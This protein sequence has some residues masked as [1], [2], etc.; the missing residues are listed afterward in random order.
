MKSSIK[1]HNTDIYYKDLA[2]GI[3]F[4]TKNIIMCKV[5][6]ENAMY[7]DGTGARRMDGNE[8]VTPVISIEVEI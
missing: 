5:S 7:L 1:K 6:E 2:C 3:L 4:V 8:N